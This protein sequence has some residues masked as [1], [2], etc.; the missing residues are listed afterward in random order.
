MNTVSI[1]KSCS[2]ING[3]FENYQEF[4]DQVLNELRQRRPDIEWKVEASPCLKVCPIGRITMTVTR[5]D[6]SEDARLAL[7]REATLD[8]VVREAISF[9]PAPIKH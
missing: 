6:I 4:L 2:Q 5:P 3:G 9:F 8:S 1:C 7:S